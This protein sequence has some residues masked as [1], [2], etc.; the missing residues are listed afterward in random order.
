LK[1]VEGADARV[2]R[3]YPRDFW[4]T[5]KA[6]SVSSMTLDEKHKFFQAAGIT[7]NDALVKMVAQELGL[8]DASGKPTPAFQPFVKAHFDWAI[9]NAKWVSEFQD[10]KRAEEYMRNWPL[11]SGVEKH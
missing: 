7:R 11:N 2:Y 1:T 10:M 4:L 3:L 8:A 9:K 5:L 6:G